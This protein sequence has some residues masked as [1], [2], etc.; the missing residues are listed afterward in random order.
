MFISW[1]FPLTCSPFFY[2]WNLGPTMGHP[3]VTFH[4]IYI[5]LLLWGKVSLLL[6]QSQNLRRGRKIFKKVAR[7]RDKSCMNEFLFCSSIPQSSVFT[8]RL[9]END[10]VCSNIR[11]L[12]HLLRNSHAS[13]GLPP[14][15]WAII[16]IVATSKELSLSYFHDDV[17]PCPHSQSSFLA[18]VYR[19]NS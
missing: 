4:Y 16:I 2:K 7:H 9:S 5:L 3:C 13:V 17:F 8:F 10:E 14:V 6:E 12:V 19:P 15:W 18:N 1:S 11:S